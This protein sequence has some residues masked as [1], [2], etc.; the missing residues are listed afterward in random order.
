MATLVGTRM[1]GLAAGLNRGA[2]A[3]NAEEVELADRLRMLAEAELRDLAL[4]LRPAP[5]TCP[6]CADVILR[7]G[8][9][10]SRKPSAQPKT[11]QRWLAGL[12][13]RCFAGGE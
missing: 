6:P 9:R 5:P 1:A 7:W 12:C 10:R 13:C 8:T 2:L 3:A 11:V 4:L